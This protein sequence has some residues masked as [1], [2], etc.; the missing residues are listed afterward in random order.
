SLAL[1][2]FEAIVEGLTTL[3]ARHRLHI[4]GGN[5]A[6]SPG[7]LV[8]DVTVTGTVKRR[9]ALLRSGARPG[10]ALYV[11]GSIGAAAAGLQ[12]LAQGAG[13]APDASG[14]PDALSPP[15]A[16]SGTRDSSPGCGSSR[17]G[18]SSPMT[19]GARDRSC[20]QRYLYPEPRLRL[21]MLLGRNRAASA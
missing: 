1:A 14:P 5:L 19:I 16:D 8:I 15:P 10:D 6:R 12:M 18:V 4:A 17:A 2:D 11:T 9:G 20:V 3:A 13:R 7:P 21:G